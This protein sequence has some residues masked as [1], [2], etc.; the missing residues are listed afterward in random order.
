MQTKRRPLLIFG[1]TAFAEV[2]FEYFDTDSDYEVSAFVVHKEYL[3]KKELLGRP[4]VSFEDV[5]TKF[6][7]SSHDVHVAVNY[8]K[9]NRARA[10]IIRSFED[11]G[12][13]LASYVSTHARVART[14]E[15]GP[16]CFIF[17]NNVVQPFVKLGRNVVLWSGNHIGHHSQIGDNCFISS[18]VVVSG[19]CRIGR[20]CFLG[21]NTSIAH[22]T[23]VEDDV[24]MGPGCVATA[25][26]PRGTLLT[27][28]K[29]ESARVSAYRFFRVP[30]PRD[31]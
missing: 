19:F 11:R 22:E 2:A 14:A 15:I 7:S 1:A 3:D 26:V 21:V 27:A 12:Y 31:E 17:E 6:P 16:H 25:T 24:W 20:N 9:L 18:H 4:V 23:V 30:E 29:S 10:D 5:E 13:A 28:P 8:Q